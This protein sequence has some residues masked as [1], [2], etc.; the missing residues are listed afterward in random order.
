MI[1]FNGKK[2][3]VINSTRGI[4]EDELIS[5]IKKE[6]KLKKYFIE[7]KIKKKIFIS[8]KLINIII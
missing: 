8:N 2:R 6:E 7:D 4:S 1:Q 5:L 3:A